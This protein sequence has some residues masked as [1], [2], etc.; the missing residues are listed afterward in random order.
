MAVR[1]SAGTGVIVSLVVFII[2]S[3]IMFVLTIVFYRGQTAAEQSEREA[4]NELEAF[5]RPA[6]ANNDAVQT[7][8]GAATANNASVVGHLLAQRRELMTL[9]DGSATTD[10][11]ALRER[12]ADL[13]VD[14]GGSMLQRMQAMQRE[15]RSLEDELAAKNEDLADRSSELADLR[16]RL[17]D[18]GDTYEQDLA[19]FQAELGDYIDAAQQYQQ[20]VAETRET[21]MTSVDRLDEQYRSQIDD[22]ET[23]IDQ[24]NRDNVI[25]RGRIAELNEIVRRNTEAVDPSALV[26]ARVIEI[27]GSDE[28]FIDR[29]RIDR[30][31]L[32]MTFEIYDS[33]QSLRVD[34]RTDT[35]PRGKASCQVTQ[36]GENTARCKITRMAPGRPVVTGD[37]VANAVY[38]PNYEFKFLVHGQFDLNGDGRATNAEADYIRSL[39]ES[40][41]GTYI[42]GE[43]LP[44]DLDFLVL[45]VEPMPPAPLPARPSDAMVDAFVKQREAYETYRRLFQQAR[46]AQ[47]PVLNA[48]RFLVLIGHTPD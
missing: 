41:G 43:R 26:D 18:L 33:P 13:G 11:A 31:V 44:G 42:E 7:V 45:G 2:L 39:I 14:A 3:I 24:L 37:V 36:V 1:S 12:A 35:L 19:G 17:A 23:E 20:D 47:I 21:M 40:W 28:I 48:N 30:I 8:K 34:R 25:A 10:L 5:V 16:Q 6:E 32:G 46:E 29:G 27:A 22:L 38:D 15:I 4:R 9:A